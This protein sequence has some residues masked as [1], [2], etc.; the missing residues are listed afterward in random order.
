MS[1]F[2]RIEE[3]ETEYGTSRTFVTEKGNRY[4]HFDCE[5]QLT[6]AVRK[7][8]RWFSRAIRTMTTWNDADMRGV[9]IRDLRWVL[10]DITN[11]AEIIQRE[12]DRIEGVN[13]IEERVKELRAV[14]G[15]TPE[16][17]ALYLQKAEDLE[18]K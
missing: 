16:E 7:T 17:A 6:S 18:S 2:D 8:Q 4:S 13:R 3:R 14:A 12:L 9:E 11:F 1:V 5:Q 10:S 15:R